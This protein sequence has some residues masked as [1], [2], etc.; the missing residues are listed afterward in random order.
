MELLSRIV[1]VAFGVFLIGFAVVMFV[2]PLLAERFLRLFASSASA[3]YIEQLVRMVTGL[4]IIYLAP[5]MR[6]SVAFRVFGWV[7]VVTTLVL[8][9]VPW[10]WHHRFGKWAIPLAIR[11]MRLY[12]L[13]ALILAMVLFYGI[14]RFAFDR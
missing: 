11:H 2:K 8:L 12:A 1:V 3:H 9:V 6:F 7:I 4:A 13:G 5:T 14:S 10:Q